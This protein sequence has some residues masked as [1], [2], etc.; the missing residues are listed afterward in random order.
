MK[1]IVFCVCLSL[2]LSSCAF[3]KPQVLLESEQYFFVPAGT[4]FMA[5]ETKKSELKKYERTT[6]SYNVSAATLIKL[7]EQANT[8]LIN[9][10]N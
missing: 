8:N 6:D 2:L 9:D 3:S 7:Q 4:E 1:N 5:K 10:I